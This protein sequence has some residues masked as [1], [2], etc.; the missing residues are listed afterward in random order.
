[1]NK[2]VA[3]LNVGPLEAQLIGD[4]VGSRFSTFSNDAS[5]KSNFLTSFRIAAKV[6]ENVL[7]LYKAEIALNVTN[8]TDK[9]G[10]S[11]V[12]IGSATNS[13]SAYPIAPRQ[14]FLTLSAAY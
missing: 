3:T 1:M 4:Y 10:K 12:S 13:Y 14:W 2:T 11:T 5:V 6:P 8:L 9:Q 7:P